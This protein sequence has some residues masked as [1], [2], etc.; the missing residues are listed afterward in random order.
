MPFF[1]SAGVRIH[2]EDAG[3]GA[4]VILIHGFASTA[5]HNWRDTGWID[6]LAKNYRVLALDVRGHGSSDKP[7][8]AEAYGYPNMGADAIRLLDHLGI[9]RA[10]LMGYSMGGSMAISLLIS[11]PQ[12]LRAVVLGGIAYDDGLDDPADRKAIVDAYRVDES[13]AVTSPVARAYRRFAEA[14]H[15]DLKALA[16]L[17]EGARPRIT[18]E[19]FAQVR[20][21]VLIVVGTN[22]NLIGDPKPLADMIPGSRLLMLEGRDHLNAPS[23]ELYQASVVSFFRDAPA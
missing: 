14:N 8:H 18:P 6:L 19:Q 10:L 2:Y 9:R 16:A 13:A 7:H 23:D 11:H 15:C 3:T 21:P 4:A 12:R 1:E 5:K 22:D 17:M 20:I